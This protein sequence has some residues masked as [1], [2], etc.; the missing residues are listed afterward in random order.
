MR[1]VEIRS[2]SFGW[3]GRM[4]VCLANA[5]GVPWRRRLC[6]IE[7]EYGRGAGADA[8]NLAIHVGILDK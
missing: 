6:R 2:A 8:K 3:I 5:L 1:L 7:P 4:Y